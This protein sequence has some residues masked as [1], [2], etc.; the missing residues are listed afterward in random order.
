MANSN[1]WDAIW[2]LFLI[3]DS[4]YCRQTMKSKHLRSGISQ[5]SKKG[6]EEDAA[7]RVTRGDLI[8]VRLNGGSWW[9]A[10][11]FEILCILVSFGLH[12]WYLLMLPE[13]I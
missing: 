13:Y 9:P 7:T 11:V 2:Y 3:L 6:V 1:A 12:K 10:Q 4:P 8:W 5:I